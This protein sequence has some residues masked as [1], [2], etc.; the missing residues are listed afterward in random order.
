[1]EEEEEEEEEEIEMSRGRR[2]PQKLT[3]RTESEPKQSKQERLT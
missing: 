3:I 2:A 1:V